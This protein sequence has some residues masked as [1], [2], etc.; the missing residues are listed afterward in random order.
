[1]IAYQQTFLPRVCQNSSQLTLSPLPPSTS[2]PPLFSAAGLSL[3]KE[4][5]WLAKLNKGA[6]IPLA[7]EAG[8]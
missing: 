8:E 1:M 4:Q 5:Q 7:M 6:P 2:L 3:T